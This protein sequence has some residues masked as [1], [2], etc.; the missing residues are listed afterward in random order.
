MLRLAIGLRATRRAEDT[1]GE[2]ERLFEEA[3]R[4]SAVADRLCP[5]AVAPARAARVRFVRCVRPGEEV[6]FRSP[7]GFRFGDFAILGLVGRPDSPRLCLGELEIRGE[8]T[9]LVVLRWP[10]R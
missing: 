9:G 5:L 3:R 10:A 1:L 6:A 8:R 4:F 7:V 2:E